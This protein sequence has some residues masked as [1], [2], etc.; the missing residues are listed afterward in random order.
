M[1]HIGTPLDT[2]DPFPRMSLALVG[3]GALDP[4]SAAAAGWFVL[5]VY[6]GHW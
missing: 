6:R 5:L 3:G 1:P 4:R 2:G